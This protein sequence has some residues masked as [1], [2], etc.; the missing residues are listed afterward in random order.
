MSIR[1]ISQNTAFLQAPYY[2]P[3]SPICLVLKTHNLMSLL[4]NLLTNINR[5]TSKEYLNNP[6]NL[7]SFPELYAVPLFLRD[8]SLLLNLLKFYHKS[9]MINL[10]THAI[11]QPVSPFSQIVTPPIFAVNFAHYFTCIMLAFSIRKTEV[12]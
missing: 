4:F 8:F 12:L 9:F 5:P 6:P 10:N 7:H 1:K 2:L 11:H 3:D